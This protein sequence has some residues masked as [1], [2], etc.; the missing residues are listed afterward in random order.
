MKD[1]HKGEEGNSLQRRER[2]H[3]PEPPPYQPRKSEKSK[4]SLKLTRIGLLCFI[5]VLL[6]LIGKEGIQYFSAQ[7]EYRKYQQMED[8]PNA[9]APAATEAPAATDG[10]LTA[11]DI[12]AETAAPT[13]AV[14][15]A[16]ALPEGQRAFYSAKV[17]TLQ[18]TN[19][20]MVAWL[21]VEHTRIHYPV[22]QATDNEYY[23]THTFDRKENPSGALFL[24]FRNQRALS[25]FNLIIYGHNMKDGS[26]F[27]DLREF[28]HADFLQKNPKI[29]L[30]LKD[31]KRVYRAFAVYQRKDDFDF[32]GFS[33]SMDEDKEQ[34][35]SRILKKSDIQTGIHPT[36]QDEI[37][38][39]VTCTSGSHTWHWIIHAVLVEEVLTTKSLL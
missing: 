21:D 27:Y 36:A 3:V 32:M 31:S 20:D 5:G 9:T 16:T 7:Q 26:M 30:T 35:I 39:L 38:T 23:L 34:L 4:R 19:P 6:V 11:V 37:L 10:V 33:I 24:D 18:K 12:D 8:V 22:V 14:P 15:A 17:D 28:E 25:D 1:N 13:D 2:R 29:E